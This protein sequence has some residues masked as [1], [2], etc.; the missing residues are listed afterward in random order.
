ML[1]APCVCGFCRGFFFLVVDFYFHKLW[2]EK[3]LDMNIQ[4]S[5]I[6]ET[7]FFSLAYD[8]PRIIF[9]AHLKKMYIML[10]LDKIFYVYLL[11]PIYLSF[12]T[13]VSLLVLHLDGFLIDTNCGVKILCY[14]CGFIF[15]FSFVNISLIFLGVLMLGAYIYNC[16]IFLDCSLCHYIMSFLSLVM[17]L[18]FKV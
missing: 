3:M 17:S 2:S 15:S 12:K 16:Y 13:S 9:H 18:C 4:Y 7:C 1:W 14:Y 10:V 8:L 11:S 6:F 5:Y